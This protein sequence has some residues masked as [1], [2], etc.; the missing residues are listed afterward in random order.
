V[1]PLAAM[2]EAA[3][4]QEASGPP[5]DYS[6][7]DL[8]SLLELES[9]Q[10][11]TWGSKTATLTGHATQG[12]QT[13][14]ELAITHKDPAAPCVKIVKKTVAVKLNNNSLESLDDMPKALDL[15]MGGIATKNLRWLD[16][17]FNLLTCVDKMLLEFTELKALYL[18]GNRIAK[19]PTVDKLQGLPGLQSLTLNGNPVD[20]MKVYRMYVVGCLPGLRSLDHSTIT[21]DETEKCQAWFQGH[22]RRKARREEELENQRAAAQEY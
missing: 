19:L 20:A 18:H 22:Q 14:K 16:L 11:R 8:K 2:G 21:Q 6:F 17:S 7:K 13:G 4:V 12:G 10:P 9:Q 5:L 1:K 15:A 3:R